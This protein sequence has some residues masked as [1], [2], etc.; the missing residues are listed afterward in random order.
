MATI[1]VIAPAYEGHVGR[2]SLEL[3]GGARRI[4]EARGMEVVA[5]LLGK[6]AGAAASQMWQYGVKRVYVADHPSILL[7]ELEAFYLASLEACRAANPGV[8][9]LLADSVGREVGPRLAHRL[10]GGIVTECI[11]VQAGQDGEVTFLRPVYGGKAIATYRL[12]NFPVVVTVK[13]HTMEVPAE[14]PVSGET[15]P[16]ELSMDPEGLKTRVL[17]VVSEEVTGVKLEDAPVVVGGGRGIGGPEGFQLLGELARLLKGA[18]G[19]SRPPADAGWVPPTW[20][21]GQTGKTIRPDLYIAV[22]ISGAT[23]HIAGVSGAKVVVAINKDPEAPIFKV[24]HLGVVAD[25]RK[26]IPPL[27]QKIKEIVGT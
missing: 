19:A 2:T 8:V 27:I 6:G 12:V 5:A 26:V 3:L 9:L 14:M 21:I 11:D 16:L 13:P 25:Y 17:E 22:G 15:I 7:G 23:Q 18:V 20:Q 24:A 10:G 4:G 1:L